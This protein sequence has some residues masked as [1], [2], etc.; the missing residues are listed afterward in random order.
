[1]RDHL[2][3]ISFEDLGEV[4]VEDLEG[5]MEEDFIPKALWN[6]MKEIGRKRNGQI[7]QVMGEK[8]EMFLSPLLQLKK[9]TKGLLPLLPPLRIDFSWTGVV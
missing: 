2:R 1:M 6:E 8:E 4:L 5:E 7:L 3:E 9:H